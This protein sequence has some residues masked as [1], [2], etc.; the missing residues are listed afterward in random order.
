M[1]IN[2]GATVINIPDT[3]GYMNP[4]EYGNIFKV[5]KETVPG[6][7]RIQLSAHCHDDLGWQ[8]LMRLLQ[9]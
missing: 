1:A 6:I 3:V 8:Q 5:L 7:E 4:S 9:L 2:A